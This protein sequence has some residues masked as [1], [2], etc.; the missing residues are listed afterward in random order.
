MHWGSLSENPNAMDLLVRNQNKINWSALSLNPN[1]MDLLERNQ[2]KIDWFNL[3][4]NPSIFK[5]RINYEF[6]K[7]RMNVVREELLMKCMHPI[8]LERWIEIGGN[9]D[10]F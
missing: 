1:A 3:S 8:R 7:K 5:K 4:K 9:I 6:L 10:D 2:D